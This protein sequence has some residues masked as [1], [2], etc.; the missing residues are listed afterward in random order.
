MSS[1]SNTPTQP[2]MTERLHSILQALVAIATGKT[3]MVS[4]VLSGAYPEP[5]EEAVK[6]TPAQAKKHLARYVK[7]ASENST[8]CNSLPEDMKHVLRET[9]TIKSGKNKG[10]SVPALAY[11][12]VRM[13]RED[14]RTARQARRAEAL[15]EAAANGGHW[16]A[17]GVADKDGNAVPYPNATQASKAW[18]REHVGQDWW[19]GDKTAILGR[20]VIRQGEAFTA[21]TPAPE[22]STTASTNDDAIIAAAQ[23]LGSK[24]TTVT[25][26]RKF[27]A[28]LS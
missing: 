17:E 25:G 5:S 18:A 28:N 14:K 12:L 20:A 19:K 22:T 2:T 11:G 1:T 6:V 7:G 10:T 9:Y 15:K 21:Q 16:F 27:L 26:A 4:A 13:R 8:F 3:G 24:A 23:A